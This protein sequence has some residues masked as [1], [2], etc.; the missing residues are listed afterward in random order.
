VSVESVL[1]VIC[2]F[3]LLKVK[4]CLLL[5]LPCDLYTL[6]SRTNVCPLRNRE[7]PDKICRL[8]YTHSPLVPTSVHCATENHWTKSAGWPIHTQLSYQRLSTAQQRTTGQNLPSDLYTLTSRT[9]VCP[10]RNKDPPAKI[11]RLTYTHSPLVPTSV[12]LC[13]ILHAMQGAVLAIVENESSDND[14]L[15]LLFLFLFLSSLWS[16]GFRLAQPL[17]PH[18]ASQLQTVFTRSYTLTSPATYL[19]RWLHS[20]HTRNVLIIQI[21][22]F[23]VLQ[24]SHSQL[25]Y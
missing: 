16:V 3:N 25:N 1:C 6:T 23:T 21:A 8:T 20:S 7:P 19:R 13:N 5:S 17:Y 15:L 18:N 12:A 11:C 14:G 9:N 22:V 4:A 10:L 24:I 2:K